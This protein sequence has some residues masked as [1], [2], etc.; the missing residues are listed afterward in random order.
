[1]LVAHDPCN[2]GD[3]EVLEAHEGGQGRHERHVRL[4]MVGGLEIGLDAVRRE[5]VTQ[6]VEAGCVVDLAM[7][8]LYG[9]HRFHLLDTEVPLA[10]VR[11]PC[12]GW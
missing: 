8:C 9:F 3:R 1:M 12:R 10:R 7:R 2:V 11:F 6:V 5:S 4:G